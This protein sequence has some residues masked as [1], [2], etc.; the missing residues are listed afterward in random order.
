MRDRQTQHEAEQSSKDKADVQT[1]LGDVLE[2]CPSGGNNNL[3]TNLNGCRPT[4]DPVTL[5]HLLSAAS[6]GSQGCLEGAGE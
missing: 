6:G 5:Y 4:D 3:D 2:F 1:D